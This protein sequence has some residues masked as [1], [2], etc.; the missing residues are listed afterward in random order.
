[1][2]I[3]RKIKKNYDFYIEI[4]FLEGPHPHQNKIII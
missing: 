3:V 2:K 4:K 1:M